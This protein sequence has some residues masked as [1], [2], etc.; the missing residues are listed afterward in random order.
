[1][2]GGER[3]YSQGRRPSQVFP[4]KEESAGY[5][6]GWCPRAPC[7]YLIGPGCG[8]VGPRKF[9]QPPEL[10]CGVFP[11]HISTC[12][13]F[14]AAGSRKRLKMGKGHSDVANP[15]ADAFIHAYTYS[16]FLF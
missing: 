10:V 12:P 15:V 2:R 11:G 5:S 1:M 13:T 6:G 4:Y 7:G 8:G 16:F 9:S 14:H 3:S